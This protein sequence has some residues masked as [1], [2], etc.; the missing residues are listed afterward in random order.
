M[1]EAASGR[2]EQGMAAVS[3]VSPRLAHDLVAQAG[4][5]AAIDTPG[6]LVAGGLR[7]NLDRLAQLAPSLG[8]SHKPLPIT[9]ASHTS[10]L[11]SAVDPLR[12][13]LQVHATTP[14]LPLLAGVSATTVHDGAQAAELLARQTVT[15]IRW[16]ECLDAMFE[17]RIDVALELGP[18]NALSR[19][20]R[21]RHPGIACRSVAD[22]RSVKGIVAWV[23][24]QA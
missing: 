22:F 9:V 4:C 24:A 13:L 11:A 12:G 5:E 1:S 19:M 23:E 15:T 20:L 18:G 10:L 21:E 3:G 16:T 2:G 17:A 7:A 6:A 8:A 14:S